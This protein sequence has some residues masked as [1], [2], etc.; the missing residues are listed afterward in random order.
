[1]ARNRG[2]DPQSR[3]L[4]LLLDKVRQESFPS[5]TMLDVIEGILDEDHAEQYASTLLEKIEAD[6]YPS[7]D[8][9][10]RIQAL[11]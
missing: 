11:G 6:P 7:L 10:Q 8:H 4:D 3:L 5:P 1:M 2:T 9:I